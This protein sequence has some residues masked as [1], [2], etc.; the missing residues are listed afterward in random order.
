M[1]A[2]QAIDQYAH[3][4]S[5]FTGEATG[6]TTGKNPSPPLL[7]YSGEGHS[8]L[9]PWPLGHTGHGPVT[10]AEPGAQDAGDR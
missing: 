4:D 10:A 6:S 1:T 7:E 8:P 2:T 9:W 5:L 3:L